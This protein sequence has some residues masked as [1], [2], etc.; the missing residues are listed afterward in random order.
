MI[1]SVYRLS[2]DLYEATPQARLN[3]IKNDSAREIRMVLTEN[4]KPYTIADGC[5]AVFRARKA[6]GTVLFNNCV[7]ENNEIVYKITNQTTA[8]E[9]IVDCE[10]TLYGSNS[11]QITSPKFYLRV[12]D[13]L[14]SDSEVE[15]QDEFTELATAISEAGNLNI[16]LSKTDYA[17]TVTITRKD[18]TTKT[19]TVYDGAK[20]DKGD[21]GDDGEQGIQGEPGTPGEKGD[22]GDKGDP[23]EKGDKGDPGPK[24]DTGAK[25]EA[26]EQGIQGEPG[27]PGEK[28][29]KG[30]KG[31]PG[32]P[33]AKG[34]KGDKGDPGSLESVTASV[35][36]NVGTPSVTVTYD[37]ENVNFAF[38]NLK[39]Q[40]GSGSGD[41]LKSVYDTDNDGKV[42]SAENADFATN[43][44]NA[45]NAVNA[46]NAESADFATNATNA[47]NLNGHS[48][49]Y[50]A[51]ATG[52]AGKQDNITATGVLIGSGSGTVTAKSNVTS[53][54]SSSTDNQI[55]TAKAVYDL[56][57]SIVNGNE[58]A[59]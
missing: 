17:T 9:G 51:T 43:A 39:G 35:D 56:F 58:V 2:L 25:G 8:T 28:G 36:A 3:V 46:V 40:P 47:T 52:L 30:D 21:K 14:Y 24:G 20:G 18:G 23:G 13:N 6:D 42:D 57:N 19:A 15:S 50:Y 53:V 11:E 54:S 7:I 31:D 5:T 29:D 44:A 34:D 49:S 55:P 38:H 37:G 48:A 16:N 26:G 4:C 33:G 45:A 10:V 59:Y 32:E 22:K 27:T 12:E 41:M 1:N